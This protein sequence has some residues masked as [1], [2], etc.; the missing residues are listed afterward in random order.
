MACLGVKEG[1]PTVAGV[2][3]GV[4]LDAS[5]YDG[6]SLALDLPANTTHHPC[7]EK[8]TPSGIIAG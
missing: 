1:S 6:S 8:V 4:C 7:T 3:G 5:S 2:D